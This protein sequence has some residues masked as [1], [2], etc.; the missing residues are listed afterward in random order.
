VLRLPDGSEIVLPASLVKV[1]A[2]TASELSAGC[3]PPVLSTWSKSVQFIR[4]DWLCPERV[5]AM[6]RTHICRAPDGNDF[7]TVVEHR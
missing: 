1:L 3:G 7:A 5:R 2:A 4:V 6:L